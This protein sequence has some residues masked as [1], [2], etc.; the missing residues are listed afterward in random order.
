MS[1]LA[2][3]LIEKEKR[4]R[5]GKLDLGNCGLTDFPEELFELEF[6]E[7]LTLSN[8]Y[9]DY[10]KGKWVDSPNSGKHNEINK[11]IYSNQFSNLKHIKTLH[12]GGKWPEKW[13]L[14]DC[15]A[16]GMFK[17]LQ[18][19]SL[20][21][22]QTRDIHFLEE[23]TSL[24]NLDLRSNKIT[25]IRS[26]EKLHSL[27]TLFLSLNQIRDIRFLK[28]LTSLT[29]LQLSS[30]K[31]SDISFL[32]NL[33]S[34]TSLGLGSNK[35]CDISFLKNL[36]SL[37]SLDLS[38]NKISDISFL[39]N[40]SSL[41][42][43]DISYNK[44]SEFNSLRNL[45]SLTNL[46][47]SYNQISDVSFL[48]NLCSL[49]S[50]NLSGNELS[51]CSILGNLRSLTSLDL[52][53]NQISDISFLENLNSLTNLDLSYNQINDYSFL[54]NLTSL[55]SL[56]LSGNQIK[57]Y[58]FLE[59][60]SSLT[61][62]NLS[63]NQISDIHFLGNLSLLT[64]LDLSYN[65]ISNIQG[66]IHILKNEALINLDEFRKEGISLF[67][68]P[69]TNPPMNIVSQGSEAVLDWFEQINEFGAESFYESKLMI[70]GQ[71]ESGKTTFANLQLKPDY[72]VEPGKID[73]TLGI[74]VHR[75]KEFVH[76]TIDKPNIKAH[77]WDFGGQD[78]QKML[79]QF[80]ITENCLYV[81]VSNKRAEN[82]GFDYWFQIIN[83]LGPKSSV[84]VLE[85][86]KGSK[87]S[88]E[89]FAL[90]KYRELYPEL[91]IETIEVNLSETRGRHQKKWGALNEI[92][93]EKLSEMEIVN[94]LVPKKWGLV[95][96]ELEKLKGQKYISKDSFYKL[97]AN[98]E[99]GL[100]HRQADWCLSYFRSLGDLVYFDD[101][102]L[103]THIFLDHNWLTQ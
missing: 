38:T 19:L 79:H 91:V 25:N 61:S 58:T 35:I 27:K 20:R 32:K 55:T 14:D 31:I 93:A 33:S 28:N 49:F 65:K 46:S 34:L 23:L 9:P 48:E 37:T 56:N 67:K 87:G 66:L 52:S 80:F 78:I 100:N 63:G 11:I 15:E 18:S 75:G 10:K 5:T 40:L 54:G 73:S 70:L 51:D 57:D 30:N 99:I 71:G 97:C 69:I 59:N 13:L 102:D 77:L 24:T 26:L 2:L 68:N 3:Q 22:T 41:T 96:D 7:E 101:R 4:E 90:N 8:D 64:S 81:L 6:L 92:I 89:N 39:K 12:L 42:R 44:I 1:E 36:S 21:L 17:S 94:R 29:N 60:L 83:L 45:N 47:L 84:I 76:N 16:L 62:L 50:L 85:N 98:A 86:P 74:V 53:Y 88:N 103:C 95:R 43:L 82:A 72:K